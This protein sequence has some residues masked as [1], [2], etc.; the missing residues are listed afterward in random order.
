MPSDADLA[1]HAAIH[2]DHRD[3]GP[4]HPGKDHPDGRDHPVR[5]GRD[6]EVHETPPAVQDLAASV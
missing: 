3:P 2:R 1:D 5:L 6:A 4:E